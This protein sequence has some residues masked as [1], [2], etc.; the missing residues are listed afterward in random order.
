MTD[1]FQNEG[2]NK[3]KASASTRNRLLEAAEKLFSEHGF[4]GTAVRD[5]AADAECNAASVNYHFGSKEGLY[6]ELWRGYLT[7]MRIS[8]VSS[9]EKIMAEY[10]GKPKLEE[11]LRVFANAFFEPLTN[12][13]K[14]RGLM[15]LM[16]REMLDP[17]LEK[18]AFFEEMIKPVMIVLQDA[19]TTVCPYLSPLQAQLCIFSLIGQLAHIVHIKYVFL[20]NNEPAVNKVELSRAVEHIVRFSAAGIKAYDGYTEGAS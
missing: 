5:I 9:V 2:E 13:I 12:E 17:H 10:N 11:L 8:R 4:N 6:R 20:L 14:A 1:S 15:V 19:L 16:M 7:Q 3:I 18:S